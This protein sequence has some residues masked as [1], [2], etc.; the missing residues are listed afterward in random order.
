MFTGPGNDGRCAVTL[1]VGE[2]PRGS[3][4]ARSTLC[5]ISVTPSATHNQIGPLWCWFPSGG[6]CVHSRTLW[7][8][9][10]NCPVRLGVCPAATSTPTGVFSQRFE[11]RSPDWCGLS[12]SLVFPPGLLA[13]EC[14]TTH[15]TSRRLA[16]SPLHPT[17]QICPSYWSG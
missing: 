10:T 9:P 13:H 15:S 1:Y 16:L 5:R 17:A 6:G 7:I 12:G 2:G 14:G 3:N 8:S 11:A 4:G